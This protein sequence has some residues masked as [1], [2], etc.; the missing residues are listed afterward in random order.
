LGSPRLNFDERSAEHKEQEEI[1]TKYLR[2]LTNDEI[3]ELIRA[4]SGSL[5]VKIKDIKENV[6]NYVVTVKEERILD[7]DTKEEIG[8]VYILTDY[9]IR[10]AN[11][12]LANDNRYLYR[13][14]MFKWFG[15][16]YVKDSLVVY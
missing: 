12:F 14:K 7:N 15:K 10:E 13:N 8:S 16:Q 4:Y 5:S 1:M 9:E 6:D 2:Y 3:T 11:E